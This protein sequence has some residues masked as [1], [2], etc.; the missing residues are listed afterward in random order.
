MAERRTCVI[1]GAAGAIGH[2]MCVAFKHAGYL[3]IGMDRR[4]GAPG[5][6]VFVPADLLPFSR[7]AEYRARILEQVRHAIPDQRLHALVNNAAVQLLDS[8]ERMRADDIHETMDVN[9]VG[10]LLMIQGL[11]PELESAAGSV[12]N[13]S[14]IHAAATKPGFVAYATS[15]AALSGLT[16]ALA[17]DLGA[18]VRVNTIQPAATDTPMLRAGFEGRPDGL[19]QLAA[20]HPMGRIA[21]PSEVTSV[22]L[23][24]ASDAAGF[25]TGA[26]LAVDGGIA[27][28]LHDPY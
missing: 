18:R 25:M 1:T 21:K 6:D 11:L 24:L 19:Q 9:V 27:G 12:V 10:P 3:V 15:K 8:T 23:F 13:I 5:A 26:T 2:E 14:S 28:R 4:A 7:D 16:R 17:V 20:M 22:A